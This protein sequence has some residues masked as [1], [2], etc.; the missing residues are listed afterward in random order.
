MLCRLLMSEIATLPKTVEPTENQESQSLTLEQITNHDTLNPEEKTNLKKLLGGIVVAFLGGGQLAWL[1]I[2]QIDNKKESIT[3]KLIKHLPDNT[4][5]KTLVISTNPDDP[6]ARQADLHIQTNPNKPDNVKRLLQALYELGADKSKLYLMA[7]SDHVGVDEEVIDLVNHQQRD[8]F[9]TIRLLQDK[10]QQFDLVTDISTEGLPN[11]S[12]PKFFQVDTNNVAQDDS[13]LLQ[14]ISG[15]M[16]AAQMNSAHFK[17]TRGGYDGRGIFKS[18]SDAESLAEVF[19]KLGNG[20]LGEGLNM[21]RNKQIAGFETIED[22]QMLSLVIAA[23]QKKF[24]YFYPPAEIAEHENKLLYAISMPELSIPEAVLNQVREYILRIKEKLPGAGIFAFEFMVNKVGDKYSVT[25]C[26]I[27]PRTHNSGHITDLGQKTSDIVG[28]PQHENAVLLQS[29]S[30]NI[31]ELQFNPQSHN[32]V[33]R[34]TKFF[35]RIEAQASQPI[36]P[37]FKEV[38]QRPIAHLNLLCKSP[39]NKKIQ[40][41]DKKYRAELKID[42]NLTD[43]EDYGIKWE[44]VSIKDYGKND[45]RSIDKITGGKHGEVQIVFAQ[46]VDQDYVLGVLGFVSEGIYFEAV[47]VVEA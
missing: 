38:L 24:V 40:S 19:T 20:N 10:G 23:D 9:Q 37:G 22:P 39:E 14:S 3:K 28:R 7:D 6:A 13:S 25:L 16:I 33:N 17:I 12:Q 8:L 43:H 45:P 30:N 5:L 42:D 29:E 36:L 41:L 44:I 18:I 47:A 32:G 15:Q 34:Y 27:S 11:I 1:M 35:T 2:N 4:R 21:W 46:G 26:E 31:T